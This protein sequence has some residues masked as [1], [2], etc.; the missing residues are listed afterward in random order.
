MIGDFRF[1][2]PESIKDFVT[3]PSAWDASLN[4]GIGQT[5]LPALWIISYFNFTAL[6]TKFGLD[7][8]S[9]QIIFWVIPAILISFFSSFYLFK[10]LFSRERD[11]AVAGKSRK[12]SILSGLIYSLNTYFLMILTG[13]QLGV[14][15]SY[16]LVPLVLLTY[17]RLVDKPTLRNAFT[18]GLILGLQIIFDPRIVLITFVATFFYSVFS[19]SNIKKVIKSSFGLFTLPLAIALLL[20]IFWIF[21]LFIFKSSPI[22]Q[23][24]DSISGFEFFSFAQFS[25]AISLL[26]PNW[27]ENIFG[28]TYFLDPKFLI[29]PILAFSSLI[30]VRTMKQSSNL[31][32]GRQGGTILFFVFLSLLGIFLAKG[33]NP[34]F[35]EIN[36]W[37][38]QNIPG[39]SMF[40][41][42]TKFYILIALSYSMLI[43]FSISSIQGLI[44]S[45]IKYQKAK[46]QSKYQIFNFSYVFLIFT[47][48]YLLFLISPIL[49]QIKVHQVPQEYLQLKN[50]LVKEKEFSRTL[51]IPQ[52]QRYGFFSN[53]HP[54]IGR[55]EVLR[56]D[57]KEQIKQLKKRETEELLKD[58][59]IKYVIIPYDSEGEIFL[60]DRKYSEKKRQEVEKELDGISWLRKSDQ[61]NDSN[62]LI[63]IAVYEIDNPKEHFWSTSNTLAIN[64]G[65]IKPTEYKV[66][67]KNAKEGDQLIFSEG[68]D[69]NWT[70]ESSK[71]M[72][73]SLRFNNSLNS[74]TFPKGGNYELRV[75]YEPQKYVE[76]GL[77]ISLLTLLASIS[78]I[79]FGKRLK[80]W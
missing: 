74:F 4:T 19:F 2:W 46:I 13:G 14:A 16:S 40:R 21:P 1:F 37:I 48:L 41:D 9:I 58:L 71:F 28:K 68:F 67:V 65:S 24:F 79:L 3:F 30:F 23:G 20:N 43:P 25:N 11:P 18:S 36:T 56:G 59:S 8:N 47:I 6:F 15:L 54:A 50:F 27:P 22:P 5:Q 55:G 75:Y 51:W 64:Y 29:F 38:F 39:M 60:D 49:R 7:W 63:K 72:V 73:R 31:P 61:L 32:A 42:P 52:W 34:P 62:H 44:K 12:Y 70:A 10:Y 33:A 26:H 76:A 45:K 78:Y 77:W 35:G 80:R 69:K 57:Y 66:E 17:I 53:N